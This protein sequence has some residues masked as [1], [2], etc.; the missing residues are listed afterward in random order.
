MA[1]YHR[2]IPSVIIG[3]GV[4]GKA[5]A[6]ALEINDWV[7]K[8][9]KGT[10]EHY[11]KEKKYFILCLPTPNI[12]NNKQDL[13]AI[14]EWLNW[15]SENADN[16]IVVIRS[17]ILPGTTKRLSEKYNLRIAHVPEFLTE[18]TA[19]EDTKNP[20]LLVIGADDILV[21]EEVEK[22]FHPIVES[23]LF[24]RII[25]CNSVTA[26][27]IKYAMNSFFALK[28]I[29]ANQ[30][31]DVCKKSGVNYEALKFALEK[32]KWGSK[33]GWDVWQGGFRGYGGKCLPKDVEI[34]TKTFDLDLLKK[35][36][37]INKKLVKE[38]K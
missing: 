15:I 32:H 30:L 16:P 3:Y 31:W 21:R 37:E 14:E 23:I 29:Y 35:V 20:E 2:S 24:P 33:N 9:K 1:M 38:T 8:D 12:D 4:V 10:L 34:F 11:L 26:E 18:S 13:S 25:K 19:I 22:L 6:H 7:D 36:I 17:T 27:G 5:T 28:V